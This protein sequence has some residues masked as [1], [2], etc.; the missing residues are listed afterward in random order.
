VFSAAR[1]LV[2]WLTMAGT[3]AAQESEDP[4]E[5]SPERHAGMPHDGVFLRLTAGLGG[6]AASNRD[7]DTDFD[8]GAGFLSI[9][10]GGTIA[11]R[12]ALHGRVSQHAMVDPTLSVRGMERGEL[13]DT[14]VGFT[15]LGLG[16]TYYFPLDIYLTA[17]L[18]ASLADFEAPES[19]F[20]S[21]TGWGGALDVG[22]EW[23]VGGDWGL[24]VAGRLE[25]HSV[26]T[27]DDDGARF[28]GAAFG[29]ILSA[30]VH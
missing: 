27:G 22:T 12:L 23:H 25:I 29:V 15:M 6:A 3:S 13:D 20:Q 21:E 24:G 28:V 7:N 26:P 10:L 5:K 30:T 2:C 17:V 1:V 18:G 9:D 4:P 11:Q 16:L 14:Y 8:G 19:K